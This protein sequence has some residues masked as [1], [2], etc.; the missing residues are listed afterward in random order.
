MIHDGGTFWSSLFGSGVRW[1]A[2]FHQ[3]LR[4]NTSASQA[5]ENDRIFGF[6]DSGN[7][8]LRLL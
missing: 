4:A 6:M 5:R 1:A 7:S 8:V 2:I 3:R